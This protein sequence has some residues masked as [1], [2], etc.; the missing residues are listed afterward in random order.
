MRVAASQKPSYRTCQAP[1]DPQRGCRGAGA[2]V[3]GTRGLPAHVRGAQEGEHFSGAETCELVGPEVQVNVTGPT[4][5]VLSASMSADNEVNRD[6]A[7]TP[8]GDNNTELSEGRGSGSD[9]VSLFR[10]GTSHAVT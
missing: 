5:P 7:A 10:L 9:R 4:I 1:R 2:P 3:G 6:V 8:R